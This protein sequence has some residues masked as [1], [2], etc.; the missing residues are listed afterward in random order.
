MIVELF[1]NSWDR[2]Y[3]DRV[4]VRG[5]NY[6]LFGDDGRQ[7]NRKPLPVDKFRMY[8]APTAEGIVVELSPDYASAE[9]NNPEAVGFKQKY[10]ARIRRGERVLWENPE[11][12]EAV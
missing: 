11:I 5:N 10:V 2:R 4:E 7:I 1:G 8:P 12:G 9:A 6:R 3:L